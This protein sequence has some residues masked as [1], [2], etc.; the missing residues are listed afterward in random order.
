MNFEEI[1]RLIEKVSDSTVDSFYLE[2]NG[3]KVRL[4]KKKQKVQ[5][6]P[7]VRENPKSSELST[8]LSKDDLQDTAKTICSP[9][10]GVFY[11]APSEEAEPFVKVGD[12][13]KKGQTV[14]I[15]EAMKLMNEITSDCDGILREVCASNE[16]AVEYG[17]P[18]FRIEEV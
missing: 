1:L 2:Q 18:L 3:T 4:E 7:E 17:Q 11:T 15:V 10:V 13:V 14:G 5:T 6:V 9:Q 8:E 16:E 12:H